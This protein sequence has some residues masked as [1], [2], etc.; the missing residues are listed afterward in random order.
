MSR[1]NEKCSDRTASAGN[2]HD[3]IERQLIQAY[4]QLAVT[5]PDEDGSRTVALGRFGGV[6][7]HLTELPPK[8]ALSA[9]PPLWLEVFCC[10][11]G[12]TIDGYGC[13]DLGEDELAAAVEM[14][15]EAGWRGQYH[16]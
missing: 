9:M 3:R 10:T 4:I 7:V 13:F 6:E 2:N 14:I 5:A 12:A 15:L 11:S 1:H 16:S 8:R